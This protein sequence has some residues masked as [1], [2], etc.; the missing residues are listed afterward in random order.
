MIKMFYLF[1]KCFTEKYFVFKGRSNRKEY[2]SFLIFDKSVLFFMAILAKVTTSKVIIIISAIYFVLSTLP[3]ISLTIRRFHDL[4]LSGW[5]C[6][7]LTL[8]GVLVISFIPQNTISTA[9]LCVL[10]MV[11]I[12]I[13]FKKGTPRTNKYRELPVN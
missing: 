10:I 4:N 11:A 12:L 6:V 9:I 8:I 7:M 1:A 5:W 3:S 13:I 2:L